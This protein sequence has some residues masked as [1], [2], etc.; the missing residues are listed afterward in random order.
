MMKRLLGYGLASLLALALMTQ[1]VTRP[2]QA[3]PQKTPPASGQL[4]PRVSD[5]TYRVSVDLIN[6]LCSVWDKNTN[7]F[8]TNLAKEDFTV[9]EDDQRQ[10]IK[11]FVRETNLPLTIALLVD[12]SGSVSPKLKFEQDAAISFFQNVLRDQDRAMLLSFDSGVSLVQDF[13]NDPNKLAKQIRT[14]RAAGGTALYDAI[15][16]SCDEKLI[17]ETGRKAIVILSDGDDTASKLAFEPALEMALR[18]ETIIFSISV[19][20]G[21]F[22]GVGT[23]KAGDKILRRLAEE[24]GGQALFPFK[25]EDLEDSFHQ[26]NQELRSQ[27]SI[28]YLS[29]NSRRDGAYRKVEVKVAE[30]GLKLNYR[31]GYYAPTS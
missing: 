7:A 8:V 2:G 30:K 22:F 29:S 18:A 28:G 14:V 17:R 21:G 19:S 1:P 10:E 16:L 27:Y 25:V 6:L 23:D 12:T 26:I 31:K 11:N 13:T 15:Y 3:P 20:R 9:Y 5:Q 24:T 4:P